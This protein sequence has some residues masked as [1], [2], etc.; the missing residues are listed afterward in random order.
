MTESPR[1]IADAML[2][3]LARKLR[4]FGFD[5]R[6]F[7]H[8]ADRSLMAIAR[9]DGRTILTF[10]RGLAESAY[11]SGISCFLLYGTTDR[12]RL[13]SLA[14]VADS[15]SVPLRAG[16]TRCPLCNRTLR[17][18]KKK[19]LTV[20]VSDG[21]LKHHRIFY[22]CQHCGRAYWKGRHW[23]RLRR[24]SSAVDGKKI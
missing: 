1:F 12:Q 5:C 15:Q 19:E 22:E 18:V 17:L 10:D 8:G 14:H 6:Y 2:G 21:T 24:L 7:K 11:R 9:T 13:D 20:R 23:T 4:I 3:S 16:K